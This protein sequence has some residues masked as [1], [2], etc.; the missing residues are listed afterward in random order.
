VSTTTM[1][2][3]SGTDTPRRRGV[4]TTAYRLG[5]RLVEYRLEDDSNIHVVIRR[6]HAHGT[7]IV[8]FPAKSC[9]P[10]RARARHRMIH[11]RRAFVARFG[12]PTADWHH[13]KVNAVITGVGFF[14]HRPRPDRHRT[15][16]HRTAPR[17]RIPLSLCPG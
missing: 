17:D 9:I 8:E 15:Q 2:S 16:R 14:R 4:E 1:S 11:A 6:P 10:V 5:A 13:L 3:A 12:P 7:M